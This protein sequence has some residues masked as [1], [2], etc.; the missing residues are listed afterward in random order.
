M[1]SLAHY[2]LGDR[3]A[4]DRVAE[5]YRAT[6][7]ALGRT[8]TIKILRAEVT[9]DAGRRD[10]ILA[11]A[12]AVLPLS[13]PNIA[14]LFQVGDEDGKDFL[15]FEHT[16]GETLRAA[17]AGSPLN[18]RR[19]VDLGVQLA[20]A[21]AD[22]HGQ[23]F[24]HGA[25]NPESIVV[26]QKGRVKVLGFGFPSLPVDEQ[27]QSNPSLTP[28]DVECMAPERV[29]GARGDARAD[30]FSLGCVLSEMLTGTQPFGAAT[31]ADTAVAILSRTPPPPSHLNAR[32]PDTL[33]RI[34]ER[35]LAKSVDTRCDS[36]ATIAA[37]LREVGARLEADEN[38]DTRMPLPVRAPRRRRA[39]L[40]VFLLLLCLAALA[41]V[42]AVWT[43]R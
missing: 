38:A 19:A 30:I 40:I 2:N 34:V 35:C 14:A 6:D 28:D 20:D 37:E 13:H 23:G 32:V 5:V 26:T 11:A 8:V 25:L 15:V 9:A 17:V 43:M 39:W 27:I 29:L 33:D 4:T 22:A 42:A 41:A 31:A 10:A 24:V 1:L 16:P 21:L 12:R 18:V 3:V 36:A 7:T